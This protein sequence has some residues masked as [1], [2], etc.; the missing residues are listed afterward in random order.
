MNEWVVTE[1]CT[2]LTSKLTKLS[3]ALAINL[4]WWSIYRAVI[5]E[6]IF[7]ACGRKSWERE[8]SPE[9]ASATRANSGGALTPSDSLQ[10][11][12]AF[13]LRQASDIPLT[14]CRFTFKEKERKWERKEENGRRES[15]KAFD[16]PNRMCHWC[17]HENEGDSMRN[18]DWR[19]S[20]VI[21]PE[22]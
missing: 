10:I 14:I 17:R 1:R 7:R 20:S 13:L 22:N 16:L 15:H 4:L 21:F 5:S 9:T 11:M 6:I 8:R 2:S 18:S 19:K 3:V 12:H